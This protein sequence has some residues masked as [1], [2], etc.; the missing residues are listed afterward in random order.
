[1]SLLVLPMPRT[2]VPTCLT[3]ALPLGQTRRLKSAHLRRGRFRNQPIR[4]FQQQRR[5]DLLALA[6]ESQKRD[7]SATPCSSSQSPPT[8]PRA[9]RSLPNSHKV[10]ASVKNHLAS[11]M[12]KSFGSQ[13]ASLP[14]RRDGDVISPRRRIDRPS[15]REWFM[16]SSLPART[17]HAPL[18][19][20]RAAARR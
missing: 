10:S 12:L 8:K 5:N 2:S 17:A 15:G 14:R 1:M 4:R 19:N 20:V 7:P 13:S 16:Q 9:R 6:A 3:A 11:A 18:P